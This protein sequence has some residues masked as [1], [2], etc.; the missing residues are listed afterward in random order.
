[1]KQWDNEASRNYMK[2]T[3]QGAATTIWAAVGS[4]WEGRGGQYFEDCAV[5]C[6]HNDGFVGYG[7]HAYDKEGAARLWDVSLKLVGVDKE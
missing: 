7:P 4:E 6:P 5:S 2:S 3:A 1:M